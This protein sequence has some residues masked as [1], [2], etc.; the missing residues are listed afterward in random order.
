MSR[1]VG[2]IPIVSSGLME[3]LNICLLLSCTLF[4]CMIV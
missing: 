4:A 3:M 1:G 2:G